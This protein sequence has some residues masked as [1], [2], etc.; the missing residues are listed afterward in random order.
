MAVPLSSVPPLADSPAMLLD[1]RR[2]AARL[3]CSS[4]HVYRLADA[5]RMPRPRHVGTLVRWSKAE[6]ESWVADGCKPVRTA[7]AGAK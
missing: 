1:V 7:K 2:V 6:V 4:R 5:G 3:G